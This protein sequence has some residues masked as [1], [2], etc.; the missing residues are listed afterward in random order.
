[1]T[2]DAPPPDLHVDAELAARLVGAQHPDLVG[3]IELVA[4]GWDNV[5]FRLGDR[6]GIR[7]PRRRLAI[8]L[9][10]NEQRWLPV[11]ATRLPALIP[12]PVRIGE[13][14][15]E[16]GY[17]APWSIVPWLDGANALGFEPGQRRAAAVALAAFV[18]ELGIAAPP[19]AP[20]N[21]YRG[22][23]LAD[24]DESVRARLASGRV[25]DAAS[26]ASVW[27]Q[28][29]AESAWAGPKVWVHG[30]LHPA[31]LLLSAAGGL[32][33]V[34]DFGDL[35]AGDPAT[36]LATAW[37]TF[38]GDTRS[39]FRAELDRRRDIDGATWNRARGWALVI[40]SAMIEQAGTSSAF[41]RAGAHA[42]EQVLLG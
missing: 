14:A 26:L 35:T 15:P 34:V 17:D 10:R 29:L 38:D 20:H 7:M 1:M 8:P 13:P 18:A 19:D 11:L 41:G 23:P 32:A 16:L 31:N 2:T 22:V 6:Y 37:L 4:N 30:D 28:A 25:P 33:A 21:P 27:E 40:G 3:P 24:R 12:A 42:L 5:M 39:V 9:A 36:D